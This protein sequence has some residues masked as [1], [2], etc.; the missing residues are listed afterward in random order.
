MAS[1]VKGTQSWGIESRVLGKII[2]LEER[3]NGRRL[4]K[5]CT[6]RRSAHSLP[7]FVRVI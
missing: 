5:N 7:N 2:W 6:M 4:E 1:D 3:G